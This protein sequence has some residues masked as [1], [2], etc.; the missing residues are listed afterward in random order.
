MT[1][2]LFQYKTFLK[3]KV[4]IFAFQD[5]FS[6]SPNP[7]FLSRMKKNFVKNFYNFIFENF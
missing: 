5:H 1:V 2:K 7:I 3:N 4:V 6:L